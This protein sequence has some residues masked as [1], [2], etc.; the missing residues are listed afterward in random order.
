MLVA[1]GVFADPVNRTRVLLPLY[2][3][4]PVAGAFGSFWQSRFTIHN[5][6]AIDY[7][8]ETCTVVGS[9]SSLGCL[10]IGIPDEDV[11]P[12]ETQSGL[13]GRYP[14]P[15]NGAAG[16]VIYLEACCNPDLLPGDPGKVSME[17]R[18]TDI[19]R[20][21]TSAGTEVPVV[22]ESEFRTS[23]LTL[24]DVP[25]DDAR[26]RPALRLFEMNLDQAAF[27]IR[28][29]D[30]DTNA[31]LSERQVTTS[32][33]PQPA[34][35]FQPG[36]VEMRDLVPSGAQPSS[37]RIEIAPQTSGSASWAYVAITNNDSQQ[38]TLVTPQ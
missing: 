27:T 10:P 19:S 5:G 11:Q 35:R 20:S 25:V 32:T 2:L 12:N 1:H 38:V 23:T 36:F 34:T 33:P 9:I 3:Q 29:F 22:R 4:G 8:I 7:F 28:I 26:F 21:A 16:A 37:L 13:P 30:Q 14:S 17:L 31:L 15:V 24:L 18:I 6:D